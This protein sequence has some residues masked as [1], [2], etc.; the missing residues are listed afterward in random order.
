M[1]VLP[2]ALGLALVAASAARADAPLFLVDSPFDP[3]QVTT[4]YSV[5]PATG[6]MTPVA[7]LGSA[8]TPVLALAAADGRTLYA[9][10]SDNTG[11]ICQGNPMTCLLLK[12]VLDP[13]STT[14]AS[15]QVI[16][17]MQSAGDPV[18]GVVGMSFRSDG[19]LFM[20]SQSDNS[21][22]T[23]DPAT[24][25]ATLVGFPNLTLHG[26][27]ITFDDA[28]RLVVW[29]N[30]APGLPGIYRVDPVT[31]AVTI[32]DLEPGMN[33]AGMAALGHGSE[34]YAASVWDDH[35]YS[36]GSVTG[37]DGLGVPLTLD[38]S[39]FDMK[40]GD[41]D[42]PRCID[43]A[44]CDDGDSCTR[45]RCTP[46]GCVHLHVDDTCD[47]ID[48]DCDGQVDED[49]ASLPTTCGVG[50]CASTGRTMCVGG[51][52]VDTCVPGTPAPSDATCNGIDDDCDG[53]ID[54]DGDRDGDGVPDCYDNCPDVANPGQAD[55]DGDHIGDACDCAPSDPL[56][57]PP[58]EVG[59]SVMLSRS[60]GTVIVQWV[61]DVA[62][63]PF[64]VYRGVRPAGADWQYDQACVDGNAGGPSIDDGADPPPGA[65]FYY[66]VARSGCSESPLARDSSGAPIPNP[67]P[68]H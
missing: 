3:P 46:G 21:L 25:Q 65:L 32:V 61:A 10:G 33:C 42:S 60:V 5:D 52:V 38:G 49:Y 7:D 66:V 16:G 35:L 29:T 57:G 47:G 26:G 11:T 20:D 14:P 27:D 2:F 36:A 22:Y 62:P 1:R 58:L 40:R 59:S 50:A 48:D 6:A 45:D 67:T 8:Y 15:V 41:L 13:A 28:D 34:L 56:N 9:A 4:I 51:Q 39:R 68:C 24:A 53:Q 54:E 19:V 23:L 18:G 17:P 31:L 37:L 64:H 63:G 44:S 43:D 30:G 55:S 12:I